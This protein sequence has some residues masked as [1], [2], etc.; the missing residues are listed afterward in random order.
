MSTDYMDIVGSSMIAQFINFNI[1]IMKTFK[2][3]ALTI[4][5]CLAFTACSDNEDPEVQ[6]EGTFYKVT[7]TTEGNGKAVADFTEAE[8]GE[9]VTLTA[10]PDE[11]AVFSEWTV[12]NGTVELSNAKAA[13]TTFLMP[14]S[15]VSIKA[16]FTAEEA[17]IEDILPLIEDEVF[18]KYCVYSLTKVQTDGENVYPKWDTDGNGKLSSKEAAAVKYINMPKAEENEEWGNGNPVGSMNGIEYFTGLEYLNINENY[19]EGDELDLSQNTKL[20]KLYLNKDY[21]TRLNVTN[22]TALVELSAE[23]SSLEEINLST[24]TEL[25]KLDLYGCYLSSIDVSNCTKLEIL[26]IN[27]NEY[28]ESINLLN[29]PELK[30][31]DAGNCGLKSISFLNNK[32]LTNIDVHANQLG[33]LDVSMCPDLKMLSCGKNQLTALDVSKNTKLTNLQIGRNRITSIDLSK[34][35]ELYYLYADNNEFTE[36][37]VTNSN[38]LVYCHVNGNHLDFFDASHLAFSIDDKTGEP[39]DASDLWCGIQRKDDVTEPIDPFLE[40]NPTSRPELFKTVRIRLRYD[41]KQGW[42]RVL[43]PG[44]MAWNNYCDAVYVME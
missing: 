1:I 24:L 36:L 40:L 32:K 7:I 13:E 4:A 21:Y 34:L 22:C 30:D 28:I 14:K 39:T 38:K 17:L 23:E 8:A 44:R 27:Y 10:T 37:D 3:L 19:I 29:N 9:L 43:N 6:P 25:K 33:S 15:D 42:E 12:V 26:N 20:T 41:Q 18:H 31:I 16:T 35:T 2:L 5:A 11:G